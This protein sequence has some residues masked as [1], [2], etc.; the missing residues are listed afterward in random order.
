[1]RE[2]FSMYS[3]FSGE[4]VSFAVLRQDAHLDALV[5][6]SLV[7]RKVA[8]PEDSYQGVAA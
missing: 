5:L 2:M 1:M 7:D 8:Q 3:N 4:K 6:A